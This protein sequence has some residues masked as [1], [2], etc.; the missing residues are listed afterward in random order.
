VGGHCSVIPEIVQDISTDKA[1]VRS[2]SKSALYTGDLK[3]FPSVSSV[4]LAAGA[5][6]NQMNYCRDTMESGTINLFL[7][8]EKRFVNVL[9]SH[10]QL[11]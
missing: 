7:S 3:R 1:A 2:P 6:V 10:I 4:D 11:L 5:A 9:D 8:F